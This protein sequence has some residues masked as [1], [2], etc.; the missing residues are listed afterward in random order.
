[1]Q[2]EVDVMASAVNRILNFWF[3]DDWS[4]LRPRP[5]WFTKDEKFDH[6]VR[7]WFL[8]TY[9]QA[10]AGALTGWTEQAESCL[11]L[12][13]V[14]DQFPRNMFRDTAQAFSTDPQALMAAQTAIAMGF[15]QDLP[16]VMRLFFY[17]P[18]EHSETIAHQVEAVRLLKPFSQDEN[19]NSYYQFAL[20]H[21]AIINQFGRFPHRNTI[22]GRP[23]TDEETAFLQ[24]PGSRF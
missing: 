20:K 5:A 15:D 18:F 21:Q 16:P 1:M 12:V 3:G 22:L 2:S 23:N 4:D 6:A 19:L 24:Q 10:I 13:L 8:G 14:L 17:L 9:N 11:A 7:E